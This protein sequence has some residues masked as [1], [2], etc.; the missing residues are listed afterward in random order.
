MADERNF[1]RETYEALLSQGLPAYPKDAPIRQNQTD[2]PYTVTA[3]LPG[4]QIRNMPALE[5]TNLGGFVVSDTK[6]GNPERMFLRPNANSQ[7]I[8][9]EAEHLLAQRQLGRGSSIN[10]KFDELLAPY[11]SNPVKERRNFVLN[12][13]QMGPYLKE[14]YGIDDAYFNPEMVKFQGPYA[15]N[16]FAEQVAS[17]AAAEAVHGVD[18][19]KDPKLRETLFADPKVVEVYNAL[20]GLRQTRLDAKDLPPHTLEPDPGFLGRLKKMMR[21]A[22]GGKVDNAGNNKL[23]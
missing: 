4:A 8:A 7:T 20:T 11:S 15:K 22:K 5:N 19:T 9:H 14:K 18:L 3:G 23:I 2:L 16:L 1:D 13:V 17:L 10:T 12:A 6:P 21:F